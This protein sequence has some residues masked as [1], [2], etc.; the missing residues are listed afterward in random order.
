[1]TT[2]KKNHYQGVSHLMI[3]GLV[4]LLMVGAYFAEG[5]IIKG[6]LIGLLIFLGIFI[7]K[8]IV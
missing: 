3:I 5:F 1:M 8:K 2:N 4:P 6:L 7:W